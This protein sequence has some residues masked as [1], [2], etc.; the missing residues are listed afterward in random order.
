[1]QFHETST[2]GAVSVGPVL[3]SPDKVQLR[4]FA[5]SDGRLVLRI[6]YT[7]FRMMGLTMPSS[8]PWRPMLVAPVPAGLTPGRYEVEAVWRAVSAIP[9]GNPL[10]VEDLHETFHF[11]IIKG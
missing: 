7:R 4:D 5:R 6:D 10:P 9:D 3:D 1:M 2:L 8:L 11:E